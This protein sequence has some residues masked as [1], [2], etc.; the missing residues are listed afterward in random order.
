[1]PLSYSFIARS[2]RARRSLAAALG[3][4]RVAFPA[5]VSVSFGLAVLRVVA[6]DFAGLTARVDF[7]AAV[8]FLPT[9]RFAMKFGVGAY[10]KAY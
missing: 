10:Q 5:L 8:L 4:G 6:F 3:L 7:F 1:M 9:V 2:E